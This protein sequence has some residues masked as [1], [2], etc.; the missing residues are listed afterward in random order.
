MEAAVSC[1]EQGQTIC[2]ASQVVDKDLNHGVLRECL[3]WWEHQLTLS[4]LTLLNFS[5]EPVSL[6]GKYVYMLFNF[7]PLPQLPVKTL[8][9]FRSSLCS[10]IWLMEVSEHSLRI[11]AEFLPLC[12]FIPVAARWPTG[13]GGTL[14]HPQSWLPCPA[15]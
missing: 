1:R 11:G 12:H 9:L 2:S 14:P 6:P 3:V 5:S 10:S 4:L 13:I 7:Y 15:V 8:C